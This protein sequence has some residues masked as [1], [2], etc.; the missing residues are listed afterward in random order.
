[1]RIL[2][3]ADLHL[4]RQF[5]GISL[6]DDQAEVLGQIVEA[7][8]ENEA[9]MLIVAGDIYDRAAPPTTAFR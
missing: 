1:M 5:N 6:D 9:D 3:T 2:H 4:G 7:L 8:K